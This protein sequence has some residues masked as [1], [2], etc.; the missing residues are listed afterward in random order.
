MSIQIYN[1]TTSIHY[2]DTESI[3]SNEASIVATRA[4]IHGVIPQTAKTVRDLEPHTRSCLLVDTDGGCYHRDGDTLSTMSRAEH[5]WT[6]MRGVIE[7]FGTEVLRKRYQLP[8]K[9][10]STTT[11]SITWWWWRHWWL[12][13]G[14]VNIVPIVSFVFCD[15]DLYKYL[16][17]S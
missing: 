6:L 12:R 8:D 14:W 11:H 9:K 15:S 13:A 3:E 16:S 1:H 4:K 10:D 5:I 2:V 7:S 17:V